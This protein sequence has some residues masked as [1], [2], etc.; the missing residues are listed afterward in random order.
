MN[1]VADIDLGSLITIAASIAFSIVGSMWVV[2]VI[3]RA[4]RK[5]TK[6]DIENAF[7]N[8]TERIRGAGPGGQ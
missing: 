6:R 7:E 4:E 2:R 5:A 8:L 3:V 1:I